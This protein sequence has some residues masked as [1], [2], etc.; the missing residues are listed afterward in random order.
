MG[1]ATH[2]RILT[3]NRILVLSRMNITFVTEII[4]VSI[5]KVQSQNK[6]IGI[7]KKR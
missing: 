7:N 1:V 4:R 6:S 2:P 3:Q 5:N